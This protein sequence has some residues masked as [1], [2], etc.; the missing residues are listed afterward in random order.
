MAAYLLYG[1]LVLL[2]LSM[3]LFMAGFLCFQLGFEL[4][5]TL[6]YA[7]AGKIMLFSFVILLLSG[8]LAL[9]GALASDLRAYFRQ[10]AGALRQILAAHTHKRNMAQRL[11]LE[12]R[13]I[14]YF[15]HLKRQRL[16]SAD[17]QKQLNA[18]YKTIAHELDAVK[19]QIPFTHFTQMH[20]ALRLHFKQANPQ[21]M[22][23]LRQQI[24]G[25]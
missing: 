10:D 20:K 3:V 6:F 17:N 21:A 1:I 12:I 5:T 15:S 24:S 8:V 25:L 19:P 22:L 16:L 2:C 9:L 7:L 4:L 23:A 11:G 18:L 13:Q 14:Q